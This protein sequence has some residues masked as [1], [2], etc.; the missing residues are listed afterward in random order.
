M[1]EFKFR[2]WEE[3]AKIEEGLDMRVWTWK[4]MQEMGLN[5]MFNNPKYK[6]MQYTGLRDTHG[7][8][9]YEGDILRYIV[10][11]HFGGYYQEA[12]LV[13]EVTFEH[14][15]FFLGERF[16][17]EIVF[18]DDESEIIGNVHQNPGLLEVKK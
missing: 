7:R 16:L 10:Q 1:R 8:E 15:A 4:E 12:E 18:D 14:G 9:I 6:V 17:F 13:N 3:G 5:G 2:A 11:G